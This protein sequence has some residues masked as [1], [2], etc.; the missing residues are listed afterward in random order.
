VSD[1]ALRLSLATSKLSAFLPLLF[2]AG[3]YRLAECKGSKLSF[4]NQIYFEDFFYFS[5]QPLVRNLL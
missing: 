5:F 2:P 1:K 3:L 4:T